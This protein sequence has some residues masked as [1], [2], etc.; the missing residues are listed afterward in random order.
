MQRSK[1]F[2]AWNNLLTDSS[3]SCLMIYILPFLAFIMS[4]WAG[5]GT[6]GACMRRRWT[7][8]GSHVQRALATRTWAQHWRQTVDNAVAL[9]AFC[10][11]PG[12]SR[13]IWLSASCITTVNSRNSSCRSCTRSIQNWGRGLHHNNTGRRRPTAAAGTTLPTTTP[14]W[15]TCDRCQLVQR[16]TEQDKKRQVLYPGRLRYSKSR[17][18][19]APPAAMTDLSAAERVHWPVFSRT[20]PNS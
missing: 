17:S 9:T 6:A 1:K 10:D 2:P 14:Q 19:C 16:C 4:A 8:Y 18:L 3:D 20:L 15:L 13:I 7:P 11:I 12:L 5:G